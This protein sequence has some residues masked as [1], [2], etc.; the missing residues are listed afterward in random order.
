[1]PKARNK[2]KKCP[3][4]TAVFTPTT[5]TCPKCGHKPLPTPNFVG[6]RKPLT[7]RRK[8]KLKE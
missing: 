1:M 7:S 6:I 8:L 4:C 2:N 5:D 3:V